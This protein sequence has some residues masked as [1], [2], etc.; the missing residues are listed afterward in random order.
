MLAVSWNWVRKLC[1]FVPEVVFRHS[2]LNNPFVCLSSNRLPRCFPSRRD[3]IFA[4]FTSCVLLLHVNWALQID[5][6]TKY[7]K[8]AEFNHECCHDLSS[9]KSLEQNQILIKL[10]ACTVFNNKHLWEPVIEVLSPRT[11]LLTLPL[12]FHRFFPT[13][14]SASLMPCLR[15]EPCLLCYIV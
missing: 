12:A 6:E 3:L 9:G 2:P 5:D 11:Y 8:W 10:A 15:L 13:I 4:R 14:N 1:N 7:R